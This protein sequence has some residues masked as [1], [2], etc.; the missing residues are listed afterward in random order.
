MA[1][2]FV[3]LVFIHDGFTLV[4]ISIL[5]VADAYEE[6]GVGEEF[7]GLFKSTSVAKVEEIKDAC[8]KDEVKEKRS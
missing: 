3:T 8:A 2:R 6:V 7:F 1:D 4:Q 5:V